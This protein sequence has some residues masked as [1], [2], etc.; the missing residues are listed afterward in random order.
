MRFAGFR[1]PCW[2]SRCVDSVSETRNDSADDKVIKTKSRRLEG[3]ANNHDGGPEENCF[4][5][6]EP[7]TDPDAGNG[8]EETSNIVRRNRG[9]YE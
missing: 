1:L 6:A 8:T 7:V 2:N 3:S 9:T 5:A 4:A